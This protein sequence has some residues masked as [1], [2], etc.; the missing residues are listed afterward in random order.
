MGKTHPV[1]SYYNAPVHAFRE[2][3]NKI[4]ERK[5]T[6]LFASMPRIKQGTALLRSDSETATRS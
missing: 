3:I 6:E 2:G 5:T 1:E 4:H